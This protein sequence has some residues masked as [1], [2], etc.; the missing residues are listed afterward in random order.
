MWETWVWSL[1]WEDPLEKEMAVHS[2]IL[3]WKIPWREETGRLQPMESQRVRHDWVTSPHFTSRKQ[4]ICSQESW[5]WPKKLK[6]TQV[7]GEIYCVLGLEK[8]LLWKWLYYP[9]NIQIQ[10]NPHQ[11]TNDIFHRIRTKH[12]TNCM[13]TQRP[14]IVKPTLRKKKLVKSGFLTSNYPTNLQ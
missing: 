3:A 5:Y 2:S 7:V 14:Q 6:M 11:I 13:D 10:C 12:F 4:N 8:T 1:G 9:S